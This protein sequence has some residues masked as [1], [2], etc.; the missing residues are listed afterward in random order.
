MMD[1]M[2]IMIG[3]Q[4]LLM[5]VSCTRPKNDTVTLSV[6]YQPGNKYIFTTEQKLLTVIKYSG[7][8]KALQTLRRRN[9]LNPTIINKKSNFEATIITGNLENDNG[10]TVKADYA[11][12]NDKEGKINAVFHGKCYKNSMPEFDIVDAG[13]IDMNTKKNLLESWN[14]TFSQISFLGESLKIGQEL[15]YQKPQS[16]A[17][18]GSEIDMIV[19]TTYKLIEIKA[20]IAYFDISQQYTLQPKL[21]DNSF[22]GKGKGKGKMIFDISNSIVVN[23]SLDTEM[24]LTKKLDSFEFQL[25]SNST[26]QQTN[27]IAGK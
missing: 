23:Y 5:I 25:T 17:M 19:T 27:K 18:E 26:F 15:V 6:V 13:D 3:L 7:K 16:I 24:Q 10:Y 11:S 8:Q 14:K 4:L 1:R 22:K 9:I 12:A 21:M 20:E 2:K